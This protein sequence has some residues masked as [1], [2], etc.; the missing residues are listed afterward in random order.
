MHTPRLL[1]G[2]AAALVSPLATAQVISVTTASDTVDFG[3]AQRVANL[4]GPDG[5]I[6]LAEAGI[7]S[8]N[9]P[10]IQTIAF[11]VP[12]NEW[13]LQFVY[14]GRA[15]LSPFLGF[16]VFQPVIID[17]TTQTAFSGDT[18]GQGNE[19]VISTGLFV[20]NTNG[21]VVRGLDST[22]INVSGGA[23]NVVRGNSLSSIDVFDSDGT[24]VGGVNPGDANIGGTIKLDR[25]NDGVVIG[26]TVQRVRVL[27][28][29]QFDPVYVNNRVGGPT[30]PERNILTGY[31]TFNGEGC[32]GGMCLQLFEVSGTIVENNWIGMTPDGM[33]QG[34]PATPV[35]IITEGHCFDTVIRNNRIAGIKAFG[36]GPDCAFYA[37]GSGIRIAGTGAGMI[38]E[39]N[40]IGLNALGE[41]TLGCIEGIVVAN[42]FEG[43]M[44]GVRIGGTDPGQ[45]NVI[46]GS[47]T[48]GVRVE[49]AVQGVEV[50]GNA[51]H[52]NG[53]LGIDLLPLSGAVGVTQNDALDTDAGGNALQNFPVLA[54]ATL[55]GGA[56][57]IVGHLDSTPNESYRVELFVSDACDASGNGEGES[58]LGS[59]IVTTSVSGHADFAV[60]LNHDGPGTFVTST[61]TRLST[62]A[63]SELSACVQLIAACPTDLDGSGDTDAA[64]IAVL[65]GAWGDSRG[66]ADLDA[67]GA[68]DAADLALLLGAWGDC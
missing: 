33:A 40:T 39:G 28:G 30:L 63:T 19:V 53:S 67:S 52:H 14:P 23:S 15:V 27:G 13:A 9:T 49:S 12:Q 38:I 36:T 11:Q 55:T 25:M 10:G 51:I 5:K 7:A 48:V 50:S 1:V 65:L 22:S 16:R 21:S 31:G 45:G 60:T 58:F 43:P 54:H 24:V 47:L 37:A 44:T 42:Y 34:N 32:P 66:A 20:I 46:A 56:L 68:V 61:A 4:P 59:T 41:P 57:E 18:N 6:S 17:G 3:G 8:D 26:N 29:T 35:G 62:H 2:M 64:D